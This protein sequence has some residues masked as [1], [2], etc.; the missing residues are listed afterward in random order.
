[1]PIVQQGS[2]NTAGLIVPDL[3]VD[4]VPPQNLLV[5]GVP[6]DIIGLVGSA[7]WGPV[8]Q[9]VVVGSLAEYVTGFG[10]I[11][12]RKYDM[13]TIFATASQQGAANFRC[14]R[15]T[16]GT[17]TAATGL[18]NFSN[19]VYAAQLSAVFTGAR[20]NAIQVTFGPG[21]QARSLRATVSV[22]G[23]LPE[24]FDNIV[25]STAAAFWQNFA[26]AINNGNGTLRGAS[27]L[28]SVTLGAATTALPA[29]ALTVQ[30]AGGTDGAA[31]V[32]AA[33][34]IGQDGVT[35]T[36]M[37]ALRGQGCALAV[38]ADAD[39]PSHWADQASFG[40][41]EGIY[42]ILTGPAGDNIANAVNAKQQAGIDSYA[43]KMLF[44][45]WVYWFDQSQGVVRLVSPQGF[46]AGRLAS[47]SP[48][49]FGLN[50]PM[51]NIVGTQRCGLPQ[52]GQVATYSA[53]DLQMLFSQGIDVVSRPQ[54]GGNY[55]GLRCG[56]NT[57]SSA[58]VSGD[59]YTRLT[60][61]LGS[62]LAAGMGQFVG[63]VI[64]GALL[65]RIRATQL[66]FLQ[67]LLDQGILA[68]TPDGRVP[69]SVVCDASNNPPART[70]LGFVQSDAQI[71]YQGI[72][73][74]FIV[75]VQG[76]QTVAVQKQIGTGQ[77]A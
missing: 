71:Q 19:G 50:K 3:Y 38:L 18:V 75:N 44:G 49:Q 28:I 53:A 45:D 5:N 65:A 36:G 59:N 70:G 22:P 32:G 52:M 2:I 69:F 51:Y 55:F 7:S 6:T 39:D 16:D 20:G 35:R 56:H 15:V 73:E 67:T 11:V 62:T 30:L 31:G 25:A 26:H 29:T 24:V 37:F 74:K 17:D 48:E 43:A 14:V 23:Q 47:L 72:N 76:G 77:A 33:V 34:L 64:N 40:L 60:N 9:P 46:C 27:Q 1:M 68:P 21:S 41:S 12:A 63:Q 54:P 58:A 61:F 13:G 4:I 57:A 66:S 10:P 42:M 8:G